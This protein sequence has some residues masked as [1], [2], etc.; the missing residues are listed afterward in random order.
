MRRLNRLPVTFEKTSEVNGEDTRFINVAIDVLHDGDNL[1]GS[2]FDKDSVNA[3]IDTIKNTPILGYIE[4]TQAGDI[5]F[6]GHEYKIIEDDDGISYVYAGSAYGV[7]PETCNPRWITKD[8]GTGVMRDYL[9]VD[10]LLWTKFEESCDIFERD[11][12]KGQSMEIVDIDGYVND[13]GYYSITDFKFDGCCVL[14]TTNPKIQPAMTGSTVVAEFSA[15]SVASQIKTM[16]DE[17]YKASS[18]S[19]K[20]A[21][22]NNYTK[23]ED[24]LDKKKE[25]LKSYG[26]DESSLDFSLEDITIEELEEKC[27]NMTQANEGE[28]K[29]DPEKKPETY[30]LTTNELTQE[31]RDIISAEKYVDKWGYEDCRYWMQDVQ[32]DRVI[33]YDSSDWKLYAFPFTMDGDNVV[34]DFA[35]KKRVKVRYEDWEDGAKED[36]PIV[37]KLYQAMSEKIDKAIETAKTSSENYEAVK[38][39]YDEIKPKYDAYVD[40]EAAANKAKE[41]NKRKELFERMDGQLEGVEEYEKLKDQDMEFSVLEDECYKLLGK[42]AAEFSYVASNS[43]KTEGSSVKFGVSGVPMQSEGAYG[44]LFERYK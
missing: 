19:S 44:D 21:E 41:E 40:A 35:C 3:A 17:Y 20:E 28:Q 18:Q 7:I 32:E 26:I 33:V 29:E 10:G 14:S 4:K 6:K 9:R 34:V 23:G 38:A 16:L 31:L 13:R 15:A 24:E 37:E 39:E 1:N 42:K 12:V 2:T 8:D 25:V 5:D 43:K 22:I 36:E 11:K 30:S 27:K